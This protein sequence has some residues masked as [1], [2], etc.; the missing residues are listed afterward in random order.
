M[1]KR[2]LFATLLSV[3]ILVLSVACTGNKP[4]VVSHS[5]ADQ[6]LGQNSQTLD[7]DDNG[8]YS[9]FALLAG[10]LDNHDVFFTGESHG[11]AYNHDLEVKM[12]K[13]LY[14]NA[15]VR[16][17]LIESGYASAALYNS[18]VQGGPEEI[19]TEVFAELEGTFSWTRE[20]YD[21]W[22]KIR[23]W[24]LS[25]PES[26]RIAVVGIDI[27]HQVRTAIAFLGTLLPS[28]G[29]PLELRELNDF[30]RTDLT[31]DEIKALCERTQEQLQQQQLSYTAVLGDALFEF[32][33]VVDNILVC[34]EAYAGDFSEIREAQ[35]YHNFNLLQTRNPG[36]KYYGQWGAW[37]IA[38]S[39]PDGVTPLVGRMLQDDVKVLPI[40]LFYDDCSAMSKG[41][42][43]YG[44][45]KTTNLKA[46]K[47]LAEGDI[48]LL[49]LHGAPQDLRPLF[50]HDDVSPDEYPFIILIRNSPASV[51]LG[52]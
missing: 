11:L 46:P 51:P 30:L 26:E 39:S 24:N 21:R 43:G 16:V 49:A 38:Q 52:K 19:L 27:D 36:A 14:Y 9:S 25:L 7:V 10:V 5:Q 35:I 13:Y 50:S 32:S 40:H 47:S 22:T 12:L 23:R 37:H 15:R 31:A 45:R 48:T 41:E 18:Y 34:M 42:K 2:T 33:L 28:N 29:L 17:F 1:Y 3:L 44:T 4:L 8:D 6:Y 20:Q